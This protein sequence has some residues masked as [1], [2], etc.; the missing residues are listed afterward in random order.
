MTKNEA[1]M[2]IEDLLANIEEAAEE[3][4]TLFR[5]HFP[6]LYQSGEAYDAFNL[7]G[8]C[9]RYDTTVDL[10]YTQAAGEVG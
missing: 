9:N 6:D 8:S 1:L 10:L 3:L 5:D 2:E 7:T 4:K